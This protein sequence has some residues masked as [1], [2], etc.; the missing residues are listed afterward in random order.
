MNESYRSGRAVP[1]YGVY[2]IQG[3]KGGQ[4]GIPRVCRK[5]CPF[6]PTPKRKQVFVLHREIKP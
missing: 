6:P 4:T 1:C 2:L 3:P 5:D